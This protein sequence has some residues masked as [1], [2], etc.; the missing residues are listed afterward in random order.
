MI[1]FSS[2]AVI[3]YSPG[4]DK[5][6]NIT[7]KDL[8]HMLEFLGFAVFLSKYLPDRDLCSWKFNCVNATNMSADCVMDAFDNDS[9]P[10]SS[11]SGG[12]KLSFRFEC[13]FV[14]CTALRTLYVDSIKREDMIDKMSLI[15]KSSSS[16]SSHPIHTSKP[17]DSSLICF[18]CKVICL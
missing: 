16:S 13:C 12:A 1:E 17:T 8:L 4:Y 11:K 3:S 2:I 5:D 6:K 15:S 9:L 14:N 7:G 10:I 18:T